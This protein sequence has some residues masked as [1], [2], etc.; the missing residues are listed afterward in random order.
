MLLAWLQVTFKAISDV[1]FLP[2]RLLAY[3]QK[4]CVCVGAGGGA[5]Q[6]HQHG[7]MKSNFQAA[8]WQWPPCHR[9]FPSSSTV[10]ASEASWAMHQWLGSAG[11]WQGKGPEGTEGPLEGE[12]TPAEHPWPHAAGRPPPRPHVRFAGASLEKI[13]LRGFSMCNFKSRSKFL[14][15]EVLWVSGT[16]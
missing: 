6:S 5:A 11:V 9:C 16:Y 14:N 3:E 10:T 2:H 1:L 13:P 8:K 15:V 4:V 12:Q 7:H